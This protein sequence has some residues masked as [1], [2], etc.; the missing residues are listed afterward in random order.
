MIRVLLYGDVD[1]NLID[2]SAIWLASLAEVL[3]GMEGV[4]VTVLQKTPL[5]RDV[6]VREAAAL[7]RVRFFDPWVE[8]EREAQLRVWLSGSGNERLGPAAAA[9][10][11][12]WL[13]GRFGFDVVLVRGLETCGDLV[14]MPGLGRRLWVYVTNPAHH[15]AAGE[16]DMLRRVIDGCGRVLCQTE[17]VRGELLSGVGM[18]EE[19]R[20]V[21]LPP[22]IPSLGTGRGRG[23][24]PRAPRLGYSGKFSPVYMI[25]EMLDAFERIR[26]EIPGAE[27][28]V[29]G[30]KFHNT[31]PVEGFVGRVTERLRSMPG[32]V[33]HGGVTRAEA[34]RL[35]SRVDVAASWRSPMFD[36][37]VELSTKVLEYAALGIPVLLNPTAIQRRVFGVDY[38]GYVTSGEGFVERFLW[39]TRTVEE[40]ERVSRWVRGRAAEYTYE[41]HR[42]RLVPWLHEM[43]V[44]RV[45]SIEVRPMV[46]WAGHDLKFLQPI[47]EV[48]ER[49]GK[50]RGITDV[51]NGH[52]IQ[53]PRQS[54]ECLGAADLIFCE[55]C[56]GNAEWYS[57]RKRPEQRLVVR[58]HRQEI[59]LSFLE[60]VCWRN[61]DRIIF[62]TE[63]VRERFLGRFPGLADR[64]VLIPNAVDCER[65]G[66]EKL[67]GAEFNLGLLGY[68]PKLKAPHRAFELLRDLRRL[69]ARYTL[70]IKGK[71]PEQLEWLWQRQEERRYYEALRRAIDASRLANA[72]VF[73]PHGD[74]VPVWLSKVGFI[75][76]TSEVEG[77]HQAVAEGM[78]SGAIPVI[79]DW[80]GA[81]RTYPRRFIY[82]T[83]AGAV[84]LVR[85]MNRA[86]RYRPEVQHCRAWARRFDLPVVAGHVLELL[87]CLLGGQ[88]SGGGAAS[89]GT[90]QS[91]ADPGMRWGVMGQA[92]GAACGDAQVD[93]V[94]GR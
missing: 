78:A 50:F 54:E 17:E 15:A 20:C 52:V 92:S 55:W 71:A 72:V 1:L 74:D 90:F 68:C 61:V 3:G 33:W 11:V 57:Q 47:R 23:L 88:G 39:L 40:H 73:D 34:N 45:E 60:R 9:R 56:L 36:G 67:E 27:F 49:T 25:V 41:S 77:S 14:G 35:L 86:E 32:V 42:R 10:L 51:Q 21:V 44:T 80:W 12:S 70:F 22:M 6:V 43:G 48:V 7:P 19:A 62:I 89:A 58:M 8:A 2:G 13:D 59:E 26:S 38:P 65:Y 91:S 82:S 63:W 75:L 87:E 66:M 64:A 28:H 76:S 94:S 5:T 81:D 46:L 30:D 31:P 93:E 4:S 83:P 69:D 79:R 85:Q 53:A 29:V 16:L 24:D 18:R 84:E 37:N